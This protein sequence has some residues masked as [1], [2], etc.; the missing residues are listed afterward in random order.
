MSLT[1]PLADMLTK[2]RNAGKAKHPSCEFHGSRVKKAVLDILKDEGFIND[3]Q[4]TVDNN[5]SSIRV[6]LKYDSKKKSVISQIDK[7]SKPGRRIY[8]KSE[9][10]KPVKSNMGISI[11]STSK[12]I[13]SNKKAMK[14]NI[15][16]E[17][18]C[19]VS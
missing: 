7:I 9:E 16:G 14:L 18:L 5:K 12:G 11:I 19:I 6:A 15:G 3:Y 13:I 17:V 4:E 10:I 2:I 8:I 1:D